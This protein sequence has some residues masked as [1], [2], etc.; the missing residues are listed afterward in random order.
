MLEIP[1]GFD[2]ANEKGLKSG[3]VTFL[4]PVEK[5]KL[6]P[7]EENLRRIEA[8]QEKQAAAGVK[9]K[10]IFETIA[11]NMRQSYESLQKACAYLKD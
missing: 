11:E 5:N 8:I 10:K 7:V 9:N 3:V 1:S 6:F 4:A 2:I